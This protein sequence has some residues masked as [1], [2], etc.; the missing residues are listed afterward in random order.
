MSNDKTTPIHVG[1]D[2]HKDSISVAYAQVYRA[3]PYRYSF[4]LRP[5]SSKE[6]TPQAV[7]KLRFAG[8]KLEE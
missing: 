3:R 8:L 5:F 7:S 1:L 4:R 2:S 6:Q